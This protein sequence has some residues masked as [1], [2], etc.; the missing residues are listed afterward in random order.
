MS[1][2]R[3]Y[4][5][6]RALIETFIRPTIGL[7][8]RTFTTAAPPLH[9]KLTRKQRSTGSST[10]TPEDAER[11]RKAS[12]KKAQRAAKKAEQERL[13]PRQG[14]S[15]Q[16]LLE[17]LEQQRAFDKRTGGT[18]VQAKKRDAIIEEK[19][20][21]PPENEDIA[22]H[23]E[24]IHLIDRAGSYHKRVPLF[25]VLRDLDREVEKLVLV[26]NNKAA[27][28][29]GTP[30]CKIFNLEYLAEKKRKIEGRS[31]EV[32]KGERSSKEMEFTW[33]IGPADLDMKIRQMVKFLE[34]GRR[35]DVTISRKF[36]WKVPENMEE[37]EE[38][39]ST[40]REAVKT[41]KGAREYKEAE[42]EM[43]KTLDLHF[44]GPK[45]GVKEKVQAREEDV[46]DLPEPEIAGAAA[47]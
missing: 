39:I 20:E 15:A 47:S 1:H 5:A 37:I 36:R 2:T 46:D 45:G 29:D 28:A 4:C 41:V 27:D 33:T 44:E 38:I 14:K 17:A 42:G 32:A 30:V 23:G 26:K 6:R 18:L 43:A 34:E 10:P 31:A 12:E 22:E 35:V 21:G 11:I 3:A 16:R 9:Q 25:E 24:V 13:A 40:I 19:D 7:P 8:L